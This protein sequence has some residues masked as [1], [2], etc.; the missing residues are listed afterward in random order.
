MAM[1]GLAEPGQHWQGEEQRGPGS[2]RLPTAVGPAPRRCWGWPHRQAGRCS[3]TARCRS[4]GRCSPARQR[5]HPPCRLWRRCQECRGLRFQWWLPGTGFHGNGLAVF[6]RIGR[7]GKAF[8]VVGHIGGC[9]QAVSSLMVHW[10]NTMPSGTASGFRAT[11]ASASTGTVPLVSA[12]LSPVVKLP[13]TTF[14]V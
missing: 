2:R 14:R 4:C 9:Q 10:S 13:P 3:G 6:H 7:D 11:F 12:S 8:G 5:Q 1:Q